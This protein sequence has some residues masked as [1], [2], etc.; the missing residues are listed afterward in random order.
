MRAQ[1]PTMQS[2]I[3]LNGHYQFPQQQIIQSIYNQE[4]TPQLMHLKCDGGRRTAVSH[5]NNYD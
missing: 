2:T 3:M 5:N 4:Y 1:T